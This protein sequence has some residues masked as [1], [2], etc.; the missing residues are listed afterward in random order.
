MTLNQLIDKYGLDYINSATKYPSILTYHALGKRGGMTKELCE[1]KSFPSVDVELTEKVDGTNSRCIMLG[2]DY[3]IGSREDIVFAKGDRIINSVIVNPVR[4]GLETLIHNN[5]ETNDLDR[6]IV[7]FGES[8]GHKI[9]DGS[10]VYCSHSQKQN[11]RVFDVISWTVDDF[12]Q[13]ANNVPLTSLASWRDNGNQPFMD[14][15]R[16]KQFCCAHNIERT[17]I[18]ATMN[19]QEIPT[20]VEQTLSWMEDMIPKSKAVLDETHGDENQKFARPEGLVIR[21]KDRSFIRKLRFEDYNKG[22]LKNWE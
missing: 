7:V 11:Y 6:I 1:G 15:D 21:T 5:E 3:I 14:T 8:Y 19:G 16:L 20:D 12:E 4:N 10:K 18:I 22:K 13:L 17:P 2:N 9:Q